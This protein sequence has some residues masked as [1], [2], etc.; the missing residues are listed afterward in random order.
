MQALFRVAYPV[1]LRTR[2]GNHLKEQEVRAEARQKSSHGIGR[3]KL[4]R[5]TRP[6]TYAQSGTKR[7]TELFPVTGCRAT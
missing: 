6:S 4:C 5:S 2:F 1:R 7:P 3:D